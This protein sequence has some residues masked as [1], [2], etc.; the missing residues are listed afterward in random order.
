MNTNEKLYNRINDSFKKQNY[1]SFIGAELEHVE[2]G[3][4]V[5]TCQR[6]DF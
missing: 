2:T 3:K 1:L 5:I 6:K 4:V